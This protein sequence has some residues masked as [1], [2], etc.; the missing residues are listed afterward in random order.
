MVVFIGS[1]TMNTLTVPV[2]ERRGPMLGLR[3]PAGRAEIETRAESAGTGQEVTLG[4]RPEDLMACPAG[5]AWFSGELS[6]VERLGSQTF[7]YLDIGEE[8][9][10][11]IE[12]PRSSE[13]EVGAEL[14]IKGAA[15]QAHLFNKASGARIN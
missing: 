4:I 13:L 7:G 10:I 9:M 11:T 1:P 6:V 5:E 3:L 2:T 14:H 12:F 15:A 8:R